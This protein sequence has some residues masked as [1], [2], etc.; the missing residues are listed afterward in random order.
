MR[1][2]PIFLIV[3]IFL[4]LFTGC[5]KQQS[6][7]IEGLSTDNSV[8]Q[9]IT[10]LQ[11]KRATREL[12]SL[13]SDEDP[14]KRYLA[15]TAFGSNLDTVAVSE[16]IK[17]LSD[18]ND[19]VREATAYTLGQ[20]KSSEAVGPILRIFANEPARNV[21][22][23]MLEAVGKCG[24]KK[25]LELISNVESYRMSD[26]LLL[27][28]VT[29][30]LYRFGLRAIHSP[31]GTKKMVDYLLTPAIPKEVKL[32]AAHYLQR[33][34]GLNFEDH[35]RALLNIYQ[36]TTDTDLKM[37][38]AIALGKTKGKE[39]QEV[40]EKALTK[41][42]DYRVRI[43]ILRGLQSFDYLGVKSIFFKSLNDPNINVSIT[44][45]SYLKDQKKPESV[46]QCIQAA[47]THPNARVKSLLYDAGMSSLN[48]NQ[49]Q[50]LNVYSQQVKQ[51]FEQATDPYAKAGFL[52][53][54]GANPLNY[55]YVIEQIFNSKD[56]ILQTRGIEA[57]ARIRKNPDFNNFFFINDLS[58]YKGKL[59][60][61]FVDAIRSRNAALIGTAA[62][63]LRDTTL[64]YKNELESLVFIKAAMAK[65]SIPKDMELHN[66]LQKTHD[67]LSGKKS[68][69]YKEPA[70]NHP[71]PWNLLEEY[72]DTVSVVL[73][74]SRGPVRMDLYP[75]AAPGS[76][77][78]FVALSK[79]GFYD[80]KVFHRVV[81]NFVVQAGCPRGDGWG[82]LEYTIRSELGPLNYNSE[83]WLGMAS[84][85]NDTECTQW[86]ITHSATPH[87]DGRYSIFGKVTSGMGVVHKTEVGDR[88][89]NIQIEN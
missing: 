30:C 56:T 48:Y 67:Y 19:K 11:D 40:L 20:L 6:G 45:A 86:F 82:G 10:T 72:G 1:P 89:V 24:S 80:G 63:V 8:F 7:L 38:L 32:Y 74:L 76:V 27:L 73:K 58:Y 78:N 42:T 18:P 71:I 12:V 70:Y 49:T 64:N 17:L 37:P 65:L 15:A 23:A 66:E 83:G 50:S 21:Q 61:A 9:E 60:A 75:L 47:K 31:K 59:K 26:T 35:E 41:E 54:L 22:S 29:K 43:S 79:R 85:G 5:K 81:P 84:A 2:H 77:A 57:L 52:G 4:L 44:A 68:K 51:E 55:S 53:A 36:K 46:A 69:S 33:T 28:G 34:K 87:L 39:A 3:L 88:I 14:T 25:E 62:E 13:L 16:L